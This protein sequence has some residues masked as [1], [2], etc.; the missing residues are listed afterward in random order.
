MLRQ[1]LTSHDVASDNRLPDKIKT[2]IQGCLEKARFSAVRG[3]IIIIRKTSKV[4]GTKYVVEGPKTGDSGEPV[5]SDGFRSFF[6]VS[7]WSLSTLTCSQFRVFSHGK[8]SYI[9]VNVLGWSTWCR[10]PERITYEETCFSIE[11]SCIVHYVTE[12][13]VCDIHPVNSQLRVVGREHPKHTFQAVHSVFRKLNQLQLE[14]HHTFA[15]SLLR[16]SYRGESSISPAY[17][18]GVGCQQCESPRRYGI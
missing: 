3:K 17:M 7:Q 1:F 15:S 2:R 11:V 18:V 13:W 8:A 5:I 10:V 16:L 6:T 12:L 14:H 9:Q 4:D